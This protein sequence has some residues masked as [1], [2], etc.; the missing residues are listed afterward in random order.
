MHDACDVPS[1][2][3]RNDPA[4]HGVEAAEPCGQKLPAG[5]TAPNP[6]VVG[7]A[8]DAPAKQKYPAVHGPVG[9]AWPFTPQYEPAMHGLH[10]DTLVRLTLAPNVP[11]GQATG[12]NEPVA[13]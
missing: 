4:A 11:I 10:S 1:V 13:Q 2:A 12:A 9:A 5:H 6:C 3:A 8:T 7:V